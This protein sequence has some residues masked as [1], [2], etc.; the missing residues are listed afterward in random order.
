M[1]LGLAALL[2]RE[3]DP[4]DLREIVQT[5]SRGRRETTST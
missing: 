5:P 3:Y 1:D 2:A 4:Q